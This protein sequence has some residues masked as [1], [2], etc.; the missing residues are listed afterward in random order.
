MTVTVTDITQTEATINWSVAPLSVCGV[1][2]HYLVTGWPVS[3]GLVITYEQFFFETSLRVDYL[4]VGVLY[5]Y[6]VVGVY[7]VAGAGSQLGDATSVSFTT[8]P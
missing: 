2:S 7:D 6:Q 5:T 1:F 4:E 3:T 8:H